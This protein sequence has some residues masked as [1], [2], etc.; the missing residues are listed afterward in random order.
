MTKASVGRKTQA[1]RMDLSHCRCDSERRLISGWC[2]RGQ[3]PGARRISLPLLTRVL[4]KALGGGSSALSAAFVVASF[5]DEGS[6]LR[7]R[8]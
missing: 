3:E 4:L 5:I 8:G 7:G 1:T 6:L 2:S